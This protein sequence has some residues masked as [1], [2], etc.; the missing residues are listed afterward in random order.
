MSILCAGEILYDFISQ[1]PNKGLGETKIFEKRPGGS[2]FNVAV[3]LAKLGAR[4]FFE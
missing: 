4:L 2:P 3:G 1:S